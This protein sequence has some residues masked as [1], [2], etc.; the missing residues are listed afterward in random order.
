VPS[1][2]NSRQPESLNTNAQ[3]RNFAFSINH[4]HMMKPGVT[5]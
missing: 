5:V 2:H 1:C 4:L 3:V